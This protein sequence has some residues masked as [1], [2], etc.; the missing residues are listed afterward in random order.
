ML[1]ITAYRARSE[2]VWLGERVSP[3]NHAGPWHVILPFVL[4]FVTDFWG[5]GV[6][7]RKRLKISVPP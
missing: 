6:A 7:D 2:P 5:G 4:P 1:P 3:D